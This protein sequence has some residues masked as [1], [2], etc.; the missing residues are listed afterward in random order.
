MGY[1]TLQGFIHRKSLKETGEWS[2]LSLTKAKLEICNIKSTKLNHPMF[3]GPLALWRGEI[4]LVH[5]R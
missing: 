3:A 4:L 2:N 1:M 5:S